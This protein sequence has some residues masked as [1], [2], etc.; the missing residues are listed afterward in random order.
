MT[1]LLVIKGLLN[2]LNPFS[3]SGLG[4]FEL[5]G[6]AG[7]AIGL[8]VFY[9]YFVRR[10]S[11]F[12][13]I[14]I[15]QAESRA[16]HKRRSRFQARRSMVKRTVPIVSVAVLAGIFFS[17]ILVFGTP[18]VERGLRQLIVRGSRQFLAGFLFVP[19]HPL[20]LVFQ[21]GCPLLLGWALALHFNPFTERTR[22]YSL[23]L[24]GLSGLFVYQILFHRFYE[25]GNLGDYL[26]RSKII[27]TVLVDHLAHWVLWVVLLVFS[28]AKHN[29]PPGPVTRFL[30]RLIGVL[31]PL[32]IVYAFALA[33]TAVTRIP[34][35][36]VGLLIDYLV[37]RFLV[38]E[39]LS[40]RPIVYMR[41]FNLPLVST[42][43]GKIVAPA[44]RG[45]GVVVALVH[46]SQSTSAIHAE[47]NLASRANLDMVPDEEW[48]GWIRD[49]LRSCS[50]A[51]IDASVGTEGVAWEV[52]AALDLVGKD[53]IGVLYSTT[54]QP[55]V[56]EGIWTLHYVA[57]TK[58]ANVAAKALRSWLLRTT[59]RVAATRK[60]P[61]NNSEGA[62]AKRF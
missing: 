11:F 50:A 45:I 46:K 60:A 57:D 27:E 34:L 43:F 48:R 58:K 16:L 47:T 21:F 49:Q 52:K 42:A 29:S 23:L 22:K 24:I 37:L 39:Q 8:Y 1:E 56:P 17:L 53:C 6:L 5:I 33:A 30:F 36:P 26:T 35:L 51:V 2:L 62:Q 61:H 32:A 54:E 13:R 20:I 14:L 38:I 40:N 31:S 7:V 9:R 59:Y 12:E 19:G 15:R 44:A 4:V 41:S 10:A 3:L 55:S 25:A 28:I 18:I